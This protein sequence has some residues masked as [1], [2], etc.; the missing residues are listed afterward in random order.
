MKYFA[1]KGPPPVDFETNAGKI[2]HEK[3]FDPDV[4]TDDVNYDKPKHIKFL[5]QHILTPLFT[6]KEKKKPFES[7]SE[8]IFGELELNHVMRDYESW[9]KSLQHKLSKS[10][11]KLIRKAMESA[12]VLQDENAQPVSISRAKQELGEIYSSNPRVKRVIDGVDGKEGILQLFEYVKNRYRKAQRES[13]L[14]RFN[15]EE[16]LVIDRI[17]QAF[18]DKLPNIKGLSQQYVKENIDVERLSQEAIDKNEGVGAWT[19][20]SE[21]KKTN[22][23]KQ[24]INSQAKRL[25][26]EASEIEDIK[27]WGLQDYITNIELGSYKILTKEGDVLGI[28]RTVREAKKKAYEIRQQN[29]E[30]EKLDIEASFSPINPTEKRKNVL[31]GVEDIF[32][33]LPRYIYAMEKRIIMEPIIQ[34][35]KKQ[36]KENPNEYTTDVKYIIQNQINYVMG[37]KYSWGDMIVDDISKVFGWET[38]KYSKGVGLARKWMAR[39]KLGYRPV[40]A[41]I[42]AMGGFGNTWV[43]VGNQFFVKGR[44]ILNSGK[45]EAPDGEVIN[46]EQKLKEVEDKG[47]LGID[48]AVGES[49]DIQTRVP[50]WNPLGLF[51]LPERYIRPHSFAANYLYQREVV[52]LE[53]KE[54]TEAALINLQFQNFAYNLSAIPHI[55]RSP[56]S[57]I[58]TQFKTYLVGQVQF[59][60]TL[61]GKQIARMVG[62]QLIMAGPRGVIY[63]LKSLPILGAL[64]LLDDVEEWLVRPKGL[65]ADVATRGVAGLVGADISAPAT[66][67]LPNRP[68]DLGGPFISDVINFYK[69]VVI[70]SLQLARSKVTDAPGPAYLKDNVIDWVSSLSPLML[71]WKDLEQSVL[72]WEEIKEGEFKKAYKNISENLQKPNIWIRDSAGNKAYKI[73]GLQ[74]RIL[75]SFGAAP[76]EKSQYQVIKRIWERDRKIMQENRTKWYNKVTKRLIRGLDIDEDLWQDGILY[77]VDPSQIPTA[78]K[79]KQMEPREREALKARLFDKAE[80]LDHFGL[81]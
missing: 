29:P 35:Y 78:Y 59:M 10:D 1:K 57:R 6:L 44:D 46:F 41:A 70:P 36:V 64:G 72:V 22:R 76:T 20:K 25:L 45:Y 12:Y 24:M 15:I 48:F 14:L 81:D 31:S 47:K 65:A 66:F 43:A 49:G 30:L 74:D 62:L 17:L 19:R 13:A 73:G 9:Y 28:A 68:E 34:K 21:K 52:G 38:G 39:L 3:V 26:K 11:R 16:N 32:E 51:Q 42:N 37:A 50:I 40:A 54:A 67:Q 75:L 8:V 61:R 71:Y 4:S 33:V 60:S 77:R 80:A 79:Y 23:I 55:M 53:D 18:E 5:S 27:N 56:T 69:K 2:Q 58:I 63:M 7:S